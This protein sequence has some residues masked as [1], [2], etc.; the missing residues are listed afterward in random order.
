[1]VVECSSP[2]EEDQTSSIDPV[3]ENGETREMASTSC[4]SKGDKSGKDDDDDVDS[5]DGEASLRIDFVDEGL[6]HIISSNRLLEELIV[7]VA[8]KLRQRHGRWGGTL[9]RL[10]LQCV[11]MWV[12]VM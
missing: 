12:A 4:E 3:T 7:S 8:W 6:W 10:C 1:M 2:H 11:R 5:L 9:A